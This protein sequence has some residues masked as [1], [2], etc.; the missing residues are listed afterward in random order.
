MLIYA[1][2]FIHQKKTKRKALSIFGGS[3]TEYFRA[4]GKAMGG[5]WLFVPSS[6]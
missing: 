3:S 6:R 5:H 2:L 1:N 4:S